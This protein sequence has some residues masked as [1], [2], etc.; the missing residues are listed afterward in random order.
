MLCKFVGDG[1]TKQCEVCGYSVRTKVPAA[2]LRRACKG[3]DVQKM[4]AE[5]PKHKPCGCGKRNTK[6][7][8]E[9]LKSAMQKRRSRS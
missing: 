2:R 9:R 5:P 1:D 3:P 7:L 4:S 6:E 8:Q